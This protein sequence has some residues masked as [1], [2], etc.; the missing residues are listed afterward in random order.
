MEG[1]RLQPTGFRLVLLLDVKIGHHRLRL[2]MDQWKRLVQASLADYPGFRLHIVDR[3]FCVFWS[4][5]GG[6]ECE[7]RNGRP[8]V[9]PKR[10]GGAL[11]EA[12]S[13]GGPGQRWR[14]GGFGPRNRL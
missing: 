3:E 1:D 7:F 10:Q 11:R 4:A 5:E 8:P 6:E 2:K 14:R 13:R 9:D 12:W